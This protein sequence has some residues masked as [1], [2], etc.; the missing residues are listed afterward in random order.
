MYFGINLLM[1]SVLSIVTKFQSFCMFKGTVIRE[2]C[3]NLQCL[4]MFFFAAR[5]NF[6]DWKPSKPYEE[7]LRTGIVLIRFLNC[8][9]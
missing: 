4:Q 9:T 8:C 3:V 7:L 6:R 2:M 5:G 1:I